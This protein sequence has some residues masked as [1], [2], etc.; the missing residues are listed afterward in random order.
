MNTNVCTDRIRYV[1]GNCTLDP[2]SKIIWLTLL[3]AIRDKNKLVTFSQQRGK[4]K[5]T[6][7]LDNELEMVPPPTHLAA[8]IFRMLRRLGRDNAR[9]KKGPFSFTY[10]ETG[11]EKKLEWLINYD[12]DNDP[13]SHLDVSIQNMIEKKE[14]EES[15]K[16]NLAKQAQKKRRLRKLVATMVWLALLAGLLLIKC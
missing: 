13:V 5:M 8:G 15:I 3:L 16:Q 12:N 2:V 9:Y 6:M 11:H 7:M 1:M 10:T 14:E 4:R